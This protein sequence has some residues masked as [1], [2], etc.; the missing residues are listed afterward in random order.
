MNYY[1]KYIKYKKKYIQFKNNIMLIGGNDCHDMLLH[2]LKC[3][4]YVFGKDKFYKDNSIKHSNIEYNYPF[5]YLRQY[6]TV[7]R[8]INTNDELLFKSFFVEYIN[9]YSDENTKNEV[10]RITEWYIKNYKVPN[11][12]PSLL[13]Y[14][15]IKPL[16]DEFMIKYS[17]DSCKET[18]E[19]LFS[20]QN[21]NKYSNT[22]IIT[23]FLNKYKM[24]KNKDINEKNIKKQ[25]SQSPLSKEQLQTIQPLIDNYKKLELQFM[26]FLINNIDKCAHDDFILSK[27]K[28]IINEIKKSTMGKIDYDGII[29]N[30]I[31]YFNYVTFNN[32]VYIR[33]IYKK[34]IDDNIQNI[35]KADDICEIIKFLSKIPKCYVSGIS[36]LI[37]IC[38]DKLIKL[39]MNIKDNLS[40]VLDILGAMCNSIYF[41][42][43][44]KFKSEF[45]KIIKRLDNY[46]GKSNYNSKNSIETFFIEHMKGDLIDSN[47]DIYSKTKIIVGIINNITTCE[48]INIVANQLNSLYESRNIRSKKRI[49]DKMVL[50]LNKL[51]KLIIKCDINDVDDIYKMFDNVQNNTRNN[52]CN[53]L[54]SS[55]RSI[56]EKYGRLSD[57]KKYEDMY[58]NNMNICLDL[59]IRLKSN[60]KK[61]LID[62]YSSDIIYLNIKI[63]Q[64]SLETDH[65]NYEQICKKVDKITEYLV[66]YSDILKLDEQTLNIYKYLIFDCLAK[67]IPK[68]QINNSMMK[69]ID[70]LINDAFI[71]KVIKI[72]MDTILYTSTP[73][74]I[75]DKFKKYYFVL[76]NFEDKHKNIK[77]INIESTEMVEHLRK[78]VNTFIKE[79]PKINCVKKENIIKNINTIS[80]KL[81]S[82]KE[83]YDEILKIVG[84][85]NCI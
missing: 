48:K 41:N 18:L 23:Q 71:E 70:K 67:L 35:N 20:E 50:L 56:R 9:L 24:D 55:L 63:I 21:I 84:N 11:K 1:D 78:I 27:I 5:E 58:V 17:N 61:C 29:S 49:I 75:I 25:P 4:F 22:Y 44:D 59:I 38:I 3:Y 36:E 34:I 32:E 40:C 45:V 74:S 31:P 60:K 43:N 2:F 53:I 52:L 65:E 16:F 80:V 33:I 28:D 13:K 6:E 7:N 51:F 15:K 8:G 68:L 64:K 76:K 46:Y 83:K 47:G 12:S 73:E 30:S 54:N 37:K 14:D 26:G 66:T 19:K 69:N 39:T 42:L 10:N 72:L 62:K 57:K 85:H 81:K 77:I 82:N 79:N